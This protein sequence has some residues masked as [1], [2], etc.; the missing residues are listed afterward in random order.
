MQFLV[1]SEKYYYTLRLYQD[2]NTNPEINNYAN[3]VGA[4]GG[5]LMVTDL[6]FEF[7]DNIPSGKENGAF[8]CKFIYDFAFDK[9]GTHFDYG[10]QVDVPVKWLYEYVSNWTHLGFIEPIAKENS[11]EMVQPLDVRIFETKTNNKILERTSEKQVIKENELYKFEYQI[12]NGITPLRDTITFEKI[13]DN[14]SKITAKLSVYPTD[15]RKDIVLKTYAGVAQTAEKLWPEL[16]VTAH[17][18]DTSK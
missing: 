8:Y 18:N 7:Q 3:G 14:K 15:E 1:S 10:C 12:L 11:L 17:K 4:K 13:N 5:C 6:E 9:V 16:F 2:N